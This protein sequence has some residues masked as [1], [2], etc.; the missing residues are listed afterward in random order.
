MTPGE[1]AHDNSTGVFSMY[2]AACSVVDSNTASKN[3]G[4]GFMRC[5]YRKWIGV[6]SVLDTKKC[7]NLDRDFESAV[8]PKRTSRK[9]QSMS[10]LGVK[11]TLVGALHMSAFDPKRTSCRGT[12]YQNLHTTDLRRKPPGGRDAATR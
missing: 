3:V 5:S 9:T 4:A 12:K 7:V 2:S 11:R 8:S 6:L 10:L 1:N